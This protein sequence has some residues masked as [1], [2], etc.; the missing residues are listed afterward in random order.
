MSKELAEERILESPNLPS[1][2]WNIV[3]I[4]NDANITPENHPPVNELLLLL[5][6]SLKWYGPIADT[7]AR[8]YSE[9][10]ATLINLD[11]PQENILGFLTAEIQ[12]NN[13][14]S[15]TKP[16]APTPGTHEWHFPQSTRRNSG[17]TRHSFL[18]TSKK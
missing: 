11:L 3:N 13:K 5:R 2:D 16:T 8:N 15:S 4:L 14:T 9:F 1:E 7:Y 18:T 10:V 17:P 12:V 6:K